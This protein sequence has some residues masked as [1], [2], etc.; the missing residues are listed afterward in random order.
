MSETDGTIVIDTKIKTDSL[1]TSAKDMQD[2]TKRVADKVYEI[3]ASAEEATAKLGNM[4]KNVNLGP[5]QNVEEEAKAIKDQIQ[6]AEAQMQELM[7]KQNMLKQAGGKGSDLWTE[8]QQK[9]AELENTVEYAKAELESLT[10]TN[11]DIN[12]DTSNAEQ[13]LTTLSADE[14]AVFERM[15]QEVNQ[16]TQEEI[17]AL[18]SQIEQATARLAELRKA[19]DLFQSLGGDKSFEN[20]YKREIE[21]L[22]NTIKYAKADLRSL[23]ATKTEVNI[24]TS[25]A[26]RNLASL[27]REEQKVKQQSTNLNAKGSGANFGISS[28]FSKIGSAVKNAGSGLSNLISKFTS[29]K[30]S[31]DNANYSMTQMLASGILFNA[32][33]SGISAVT[34]GAVSGLNN[35]AQYSS[36]TNAALSSMMSALTQLKN[37]LATAFAPILTVVAPYITA[38][39]NMLS[40]AITKIGMFIAALTGQKTFT[41]AVAVQQDYAKS[42]QKS[43]N[44]ANKSTNA[45]NKFASAANKSTNAT[46]KNTDAKKKSTNATKK[47]NKENQKYL[48]GLDEIRRFETQKDTNTKTKT[49]STKTPSVKTP[50][51][52]S[53]KTP[54]TKAGGLGGLS[55]S[56][57]FKTVKIDSGISDLA[58]K[59]KKMIAA[60][61]WEGL[62]K[63]LA[64]KINGVL[65]KI[66]DAINW[67]NVGPKITK[68]VNA[69][70]R[71]FNSL[72]DNINW[73]LLGRTVGAGIN[74]LVNTL[75]LLLEGINWKN[76][77]SKLAVGVN[78]LFKEVN[79]SN[80]GRLFAN[81][82]NTP[83]KMLQG[84]VNTLNWNLIGLSIAQLLNGAI[85]K[86]DVKTIGSSLSGFA[87]GILTTLNTALINTNWS[88]LGTKLAQLLKSI[89]WIG[90]VVNAITVAG[91]IVTALTQTGVSFMDELAKGIEKGASNF[92]SKGLSALVDFTANLRQNAGKLVDS[93]LN[94]MLN[95][96]KGIA[97]AMPD[98]IKDVPQIVINICGVINDNMPKILATGVKIIVILLKG[99]I[100]SI[101]T[102]IANIP[103]IIKAI[104]AVF[105]AFGW[106]SLGKNIIKGIK[107]GISS[108][109]SA[110]AKAAGDVHSS[111]VNAIK[112]L[113]G[114]M[115]EIGTKGVTY[116]GNGIRGGLAALKQTARNIV[117]Y[118][119]SGIKSLPSKMVSKATDAI[120]KFK[121]KFSVKN[122]ISLGKNIIKGIIQGIADNVYLLIAKIGDV[123]S[124]ALDSAKDFLGIHSPSRVFRD[125]IGKM[126]PAGITVGIEKS[127]PD[128]LR[129]LQNQV[130]KLTNIN[131]KTPNIAQ[132]T[133]I[134]AK[135]AAAISTNGINIQN[136][137]NLKD[138]LNELLTAINN[139]QNADN[140]KNKNVTYKL[141]AQ[142]NRRTLF[143]EVI[144]EAKLRQMGNGNNPFLLA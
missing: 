65:Q 117:S 108:M 44:T 128:T 141:T 96:A 106:M 5:L 15:S 97:D 70:T 83:F 80:V 130:D 95:L 81:G 8:E 1:E 62:G 12:V 22:E 144:N 129:S 93:G 21:E 33:F 68:F 76:L 82:I 123:A 92:I 79:W 101:P 54:S 9:I 28:I 109:R 14:R 58:N 103:Q 35:L 87:K 24:D 52:P 43:T 3:G 39:I 50:K 46:K 6:Q 99:M 67:K 17:A 56:D 63:F 135:I 140:D 49:P 7:L 37:S 69:F 41:K 38:F 84:A 47:A 98:I 2:L 4:T 133:I 16:S 139:L 29:L 100:K 85:A 72:V 51:T 110:A 71:T 102:L 116:V 105:E 18:N 138:L 136:N 57:M 111:I 107:N 34:S 142:L 132:G 94:L 26:K 89:D 30:G 88:Q 78:G 104:V 27:E 74:T 121:N 91:S 75:N 134:P 115:K 66:Y 55:P 40:A 114:K 32:V 131:V 45:S 126:I 73:D 36:T 20:N 59:I 61:D 77:G 112:N 120:S 31:T 118:I 143:D 64:Q 86:I 10:N 48:S 42:L 125:Q 124:D 90:I 127:F 113:P 11:V 122:F 19:S 119:I 53:T 137:E 23:G 25:N 13:S 60:Q